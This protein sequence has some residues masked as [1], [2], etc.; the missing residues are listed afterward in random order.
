MVDF[1]IDSKVRPEELWRL[2]QHPDLRSA[3]GNY[4]PSLSAIQMDM[5]SSN[6]AIA[7]VRTPSGEGVGFFGVEWVNPDCIKLSAACLDR[8]GIRG[9]P[10]LDLARKFI[11]QLFKA[12][13]IIK[14]VAEIAAENR[15]SLLI[16]AAL[17]FTR[18]GVNRASLVYRDRVVDQVYLGLTRS[19]WNELRR[20]RQPATTSLD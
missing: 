3:F 6:R 4:V 9:K 7:L 19:D 1:I 13:G 2:M 18:E 5:R 14:L 17:G 15:Q 8:E 20:K 12:G 11:N 10:A 16:A